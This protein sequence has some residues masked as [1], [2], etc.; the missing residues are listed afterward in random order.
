MSADWVMYAGMTAWIGISLYL[1]FLARKQASI[2]MRI[3]RM[4]ADS[5]EGKDV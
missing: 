2:T 1:F 5:Q 4:E 3:R